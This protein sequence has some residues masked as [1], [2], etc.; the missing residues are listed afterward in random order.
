M[1]VERLSARY[2]RSVMSLAIENNQLEEVH[3][4]FLSIQQALNDSRDLTLM[5]KSPILKPDQK[6]DVL[7]RVF[8]PHVQKLTRN[9]LRL[10]VI[11]GR[12]M[13]LPDI[14][15]AFEN[16]YQQLQQ[17]TPVTITTASPLDDGMLEKIQTLLKESGR[18]K[19]TEWNKEV[20]EDILGG[21]ILEFDDQVV[22]AS[23]RRKLEQ[24]KR[25]LV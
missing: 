13:Y 25:K 19:K 1:S 23:V 10:I 4:D 8:S 11:K 6:G 21:F 12:E 9:F 7:D 20:D 2:A 5:V 17:V 15:K 22:D 3:N 18:V 24:L 14:V 16:Q